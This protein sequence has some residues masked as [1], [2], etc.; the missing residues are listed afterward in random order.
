MT[1]DEGVEVVVEGAGASVVVVG[2]STPVRPG[3]A[4]DSL[5]IPRP[6]S[7]FPP[8][9]DDPGAATAESGEPEDKDV[10]GLETAPA[11]ERDVDVVVVDADV[12]GATAVDAVEFWTVESVLWVSVVVLGAGA[13]GVVRIVPPV[14]DPV[15]LPG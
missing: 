8:L 7:D 11:N 15:V 13:V 10:V 14:A 2:V 5:F 4:V 12:V 6:P 9:L 1:G 3:M